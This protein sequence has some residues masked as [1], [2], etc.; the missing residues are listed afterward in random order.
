M[1]REALEGPRRHSQASSYNV[2]HEG[3]PAD[4]TAKPQSSAISTATSS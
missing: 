2:S 1:Q 4:E 3:Q